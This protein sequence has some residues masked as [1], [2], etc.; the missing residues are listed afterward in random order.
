M[1]RT[2]PAAHQM[3]RNLRLKICILAPTLFSVLFASILFLNK[4]AIQ[5]WVA[6]PN[7]AKLTSITAPAPQSTTPTKPTTEPEPKPN[8]DTSMQ[9]KAEASNEPEPE[10][11]ADA[12]F[13]INEASG[14]FVTNMGLVFALVYSFIFGRAYGRYDSISQNFALQ[15]SLLHQL[16]NLIRLVDLDHEAQLDLLTHLRAYAFQIRHEI[17]TGE[18][19]QEVGALD[20]LYR[21]VPIVKDLHVFGHS[22]AKEEEHQLSGAQRFDANMLDASL[23]AIQALNIA[24][25]SQWD[26]FDKKIHPIIWLLLILSANLTFFGVLL[27]QSG[28]ITHDF[29]MCLCT[30]VSI[31][32]VM[33]TLS[34]LDQ[35]HA[36]FIRIDVSRIDLIFATHNSNTATTWTS[37]SELMIDLNQR[38]SEIWGDGSHFIN[39]HKTNDLTQIIV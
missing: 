31:C 18:A 14:I 20:D 27:M 1:I 2:T 4:P 16:V 11:V 9:R 23:E 34:D 10:S 32:C 26:L 33:S 21:V 25:Y 35:F 22:S 38:S 13:E 30:V 17:L 3:Y 8:T 37:K 29:M 36:G 28:H 5:H 39:P 24:R 7:N 6:P 15:V 12:P 19:V